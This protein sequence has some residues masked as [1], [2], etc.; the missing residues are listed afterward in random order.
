MSRAIDPRNDGSFRSETARADLEAT[1]ERMGNTLE[2]L[3]ARL[4]PNRLKQQA[5]D[6]V[7]DATIGR[8]QKMANT[9]IDKAKGAGRTVTD[10][11]RENPIPAAMIAAGISWLAWSSRRSGSSPE[12][13]YETSSVIREREYETPEQLYATQAVRPYPESPYSE[14]SFE[15]SDVSST[16]EKVRDKASEAAESVQDVTQRAKETTRN[17]ATNVAQTAR[18]QSDRVADAF[19]SNPLPIGFIAAALGLAAGFAAPSTRKES[20]LVGE[21]RDELMDKA[22]ELVTEKKDQARRVAKRVVSEARSTA[23]QAARE[24][25]LTRGP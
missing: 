10:V 4:N 21:K 3:S 24:E 16:T 8:V 14:T 20:E 7:R 9:T 2:E 11:V 5:K 15:S 25:G 19:Q 1:R 23:T 6:K 13:E 17:A 12:S 18:A 22:R